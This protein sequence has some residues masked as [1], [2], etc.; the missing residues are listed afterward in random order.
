M[1]FRLFTS[2]ISRAAVLP[3]SWRSVT[4]SPGIQEKLWKL[5]KLNHVAIAV[6]DLDQASKM[7]R[8][9]LGAD[10]SDVQDLPEH[11]VSTIFVNLGNTKLELLHPLG[12]NSPIAGFLKKKTDGGIHHICIEVDDIKEA[13][14]DLQKHNIRALNPEP[15]I[16]AHGKPVVFLHPK[17]CGGVLVEME[18]A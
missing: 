18:Q 12:E 6:P 15:K 11:G 5:G 1:A 3:L 2:K 14:K 9:I 7:Y 17:D 16:G 10:V 4:N 8:N 13:M